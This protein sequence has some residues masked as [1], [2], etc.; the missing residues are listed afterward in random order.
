LNEA[1]AAKVLPQ[2]HL[3]LLPGIVAEILLSPDRLQAMR[4]GATSI[5]KP[6]AA[7]TIAGAMQELVT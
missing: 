7:I 4:I 1:G 2:D 5:A 6:D 3:D